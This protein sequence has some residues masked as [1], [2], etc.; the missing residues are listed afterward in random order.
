MEAHLR[1][2]GD[3]TVISISGSLSIEET[4]P[5]QRVCVQNFAGQK[6]IFN[7]QNANF[8]GSTGIQAFLETLQTMDAGPEQNVRIVGVRTE[9][10]RMISS[11]E[12]KKIEFFED[13][14]QALKDWPNPCVPSSNDD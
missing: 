14:A 2:M 4:Q 3:V 5:F 1:R 13:D 12:S 6:V 10:K 7:M 11:L 8:V 9:F